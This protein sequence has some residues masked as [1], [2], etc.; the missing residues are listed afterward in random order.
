M[1]REAAKYL[2]PVM[3]LALGCPPASS[4]DADGG[5]TAGNDGGPQASDAAGLQGD[6]G[7][8]PL[9]D[10]GL[11]SSDGGG[12]TTGDGGSSPSSDGGSA[13]RVDG[14]VASS[15]GGAGPFTV[16]G[17]ADRYDGDAGGYRELRAIDPVSGASAL[18]KTVPGMTWTGMGTN[19][20]DP[21]LRRIHVIGG[22]AQDYRSR[23]YTLAA[24]SGDLVASPL[25]E[26]MTPGT[27]AGYGLDYNWSGGL[28]VRS[29][30]KLVG[31]TWAETGDAGSEQLRSIDPMTGSTTLLGTTSGLDW[32]IGGAT[33]FDP[34]SDT[35]YVIGS[36]NA[37]TR[38][39]LFSIDGKTGAVLANPLIDGNGGPSDAGFGLSW[40][41]GIHVRSDGTL[42]G[43]S[44]AYS[45]TAN[46][47]ELR[48]LDKATGATSVIQQLPGFGWVLGGQAVIDRAR[49]VLFVMGS[50]SQDTATRLF[51]IDAVTGEVLASP[52]IDG[53]NGGTPDA[54][55]W[56]SGWSGGLYIVR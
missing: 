50:S 54:G 8:L 35:F 34:T 40:P 41:A 29:D 9:G 20:Y 25:M 49:D 7:N 36:S 32:V 23:L 10:S 28:G 3:L 56:G 5:A 30:G 2:L 27:D 37:D 13:G 55:G 4:G 47:T 19:A 45:G 22:A 48:S 51:V 26:P 6:A 46:T 31:V 24:V 52:A 53:T 16:I 44:M 18:I 14:S 21:A 33:A 42:V 12:A 38:E 15:D 17:L 43:L 1:P 11:A 39:R